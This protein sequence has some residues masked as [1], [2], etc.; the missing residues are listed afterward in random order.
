MSLQN[1]TSVFISSYVGSCI[2][3]LAGAVVLASYVRYPHWRRTVS[4]Q[5]IVIQTVCACLDSLGVV[6]LPAHETWS[7]QLQAF[8][9]QFFGCSGLLWAVVISFVLLKLSGTAK[10]ISQYKPEHHFGKF[11]LFVWS[12][13]IT[14]G[15]SPFITGDYDRVNEGWCWI[16]DAKTSGSVERIAL[17]YGLAWVMF[18]Y[19]LLSYLVVRYRM[20]KMTKSV[21]DIQSSPTTK[22]CVSS[23]ET[24]GS[25]RASTDKDPFPIPSEAFSQQTTR[26][27]TLRNMANKL[28][29]YPIV[30]MFSFLFM[31]IARVWQFCS[32]DTSPPNE[33]IAVGILLLRMQGFY[34]L[35]LLMQQRSVR[36]DW[37]KDIRALCFYTKH[38]FCIR[39]KVE[40][41]ALPKCN[42]QL[43]EGKPD[44]PASNNS[45]AIDEEI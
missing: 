43:E 27:E 3:G 33:L 30:Y 21:S 44:A 20:L 6:A 32:T 7:C 11:H 36:N 19:I 5:L 35:L 22:V 25:E 13:S 41:S 45:N 18:I 14:A 15:F 40:V 38:C 31:T 8:A 26:R 12:I 1:P 42:R 16:S 24:S 23:V 4:R 28:L 2:G 39:V 29:Y 10:S 9:I 17:Y 34:N 37:Y